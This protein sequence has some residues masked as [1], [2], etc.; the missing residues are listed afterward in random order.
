MSDK[1]SLI[2][3]RNIIELVI[4]ANVISFRE[5]LFLIKKFGPDPAYLPMDIDVSLDSKDRFL[6]LVDI[7]MRMN[8]ISP[9]GLIDL[10]HSIKMRKVDYSSNPQP[11]SY[12]GETI[13][14]LDHDD[15][16]INCPAYGLNPVRY[17]AYT[18]SLVSG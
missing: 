12:P 1:L 18:M 15:K 10:P 16:W 7:C 13:I 17:W 6:V 9:N 5:M 3:L 8:Q 11:R 2:V 4:S 14:T